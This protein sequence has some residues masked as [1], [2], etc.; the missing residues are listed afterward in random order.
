MISPDQ[1]AKL[2]ELYDQYQNSLC[3][4]DPERASAGIAFKEYLGILHSTHAADIAFDSFRRE[5]ILCC[6][7]F[8]RKNKAP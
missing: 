2:A 1:L 5:A 6:R 7:D 4:L 3:P 8:L